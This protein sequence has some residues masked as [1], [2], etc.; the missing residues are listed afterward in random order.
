MKTQTE[1]KTTPTPINIERW[2]TMID[3]HGREGEQNPVFHTPMGEVALLIQP[4]IGLSDRK[5]MADSFVRAV[6]SHEALLGAINNV[7]QYLADIHSD[8]IPPAV[9]LKNAL[10]L[11]EGK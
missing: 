3:E 9:R 8:E 4:G 10:A 5:I 7:L 11:A 1:S 2:E 6:N